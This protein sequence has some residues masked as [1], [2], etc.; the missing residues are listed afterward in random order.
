MSNETFHYWQI[1]EVAHDKKDS[2]VL[3]ITLQLT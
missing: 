1:L 3:T 2:L